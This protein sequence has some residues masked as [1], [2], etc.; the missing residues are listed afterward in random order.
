MAEFNT[1]QHKSYDGGLNNASSRKSIDRN[2]ASVLENWDITYKGRLICRKGLTQ[3]GGTLANAVKSGGVYRQSSGDKL[4]IQHSTTVQYLSGTTWTNLGST[5]TVADGAEDMWFESC[6]AND[7]IYFSSEDNDLCHWDGGAGGLTV[8]AASTPSGNVIR[9][10][11]NHMFHINNVDISGTKYSNRVYWSD[12]GD[13]ETYTTATS[14]IDI[15]GE[16]KAIT[17]NIL[18]NSLVIFKE[19]SYLFLSGYGS[20]SWTLSASSSNIQNVDSS[21]GTLS[22]RGTVRVGANELWFID[23][24][25]LIRRIKQT[26]YGYDSEVMSTNLNYSPNLTYLSNASAWYDDDKIYFA[27]TTGSA[28]SNNKVLVFDRKASKRNGNKEAWTTYTG[29]TPTALLTFG[30]S[31]ILHVLSGTKVYKH[32]EDDDDGTAIECRYDSKNDDY[33]MPERYKKYTYGYIFSDSQASETI[34]IHAS[35]DG[36]SFAH[37]ANLSLASTGTPL[38]DT[39]PATMGPTGSFILG[40]TTDIEKKYYF[41]DGGGTIT[42]KSVITSIRATTDEQIYVDSFTNHFVP[43][44]LR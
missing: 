30:S 5:T 6:P 36:K 43:R 34:R 20:S 26:D 10:Y 37:L 9:W 2:Q 3:L 19:N 11:Q 28:T 15:P 23:N 8:E 41:A 25:G 14:F 29:W 40:G 16:G 12:F 42:G 33:D 18:G 44:S 1:Y 13:P 27:V 7:E 32:V 38:G 39:G 24:Q 17:M 4:L 21:V 35:I 22:K 31:P